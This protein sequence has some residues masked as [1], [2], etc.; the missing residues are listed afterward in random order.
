METAESKPPCPTCD[1]SELDA[2]GC[3][4]DRIKAQAAATAEGVKVLDPHRGEYDAARKVYTDARALAQKDVD[5]AKAALDPLLQDLI[6]R[7]S[8]EKKKC[9]DDAWVKV[10]ADLVACLP[11]LGCPMPDCE[12]DVSVSS[13]P[14]HPDTQAS[15]KARAQGFRQ[16]ATELN[17]LF[18]GLVG[19]PTALKARAADY[20]G[21][22]E[23]LVTNAGKDTERKQTANWY[24]QALVLNWRLSRVWMGYPTVAAYLDCLCHILT[25]MLKAWK[26]I[27]V[28][29]GIAAERACCDLRAKSRCDQLVTSTVDDIL[30]QCPDKDPGHGPHCP[31]DCG[32]EAAA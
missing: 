8:Q 24:A 13:D 26:A 16:R 28:I 2:L 14:E 9:L 11:P 17:D 4:A 20:R 22:A 10:Q 3:E 6:C 1:L 27:A 25:C 12:F 29:E 30:A 15:L 31:P 19:E 23:T 5:A 7:L 32:H 21:Q 18:V